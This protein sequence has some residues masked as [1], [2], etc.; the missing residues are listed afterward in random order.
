MSMMFLIIFR[1]HSEDINSISM[2]TKNF[3]GKRES[4][5]HFTKKKKKKSIYLFNYDP[6]PQN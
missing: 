2:G 5:L 3:L 1:E 4:T 6:I